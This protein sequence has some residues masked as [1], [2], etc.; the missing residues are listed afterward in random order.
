VLDPCKPFPVTFHHL[1]VR[2]CQDFC[3]FLFADDSLMAAP[4]LGYLA[5]P[6]TFIYC[7]VLYLKVI[8]SFSERFLNHDSEKGLER[9]DS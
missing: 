8:C 5:L 2:L 1:R 3:C 4:Q 6:F 9:N 7:I